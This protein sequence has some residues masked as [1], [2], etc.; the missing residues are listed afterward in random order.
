MRSPL[1]GKKIIVIGAGVGGL[2]AGILLA[3]LGFEVTIVEKN[4]QP[5]GLMN[6]YRRGGMDC[7]VGVHYVGALGSDE[8]LGRMFRVLDIDAE[9]LFSRM[10]RQGVVD[11]YLFDDF[12]FDFPTGIDEYERRLRDAFPAD[13][14][15]LNVLLANLRDI[16]SRMMDTLFL[17]NQGDPFSSIAYVRPMG[18]LLDELGAS[19]GLR[20]VLAVP[21]QLIGVELHECPIL[22]H[23][24]VTAG[25]LLSSWRLK[26][27]GARMTE[28]FADRYRRLKGHLWLNQAVVKINVENKRVTGVDLSTGERLKADGVVAAVHPKVL[29]G[30]LDHKTLRPSLEER[31]RGFKETDGVVAVHVALDAAAHPDID[32]NLYRLHADRNGQVKDGVFYQIRRGGR[33][34]ETLLSMITRSHY[35]DWLSWEHTQTGRRGEDYVEKKLALARDLQAQAERVLRPL[36]KA[37]LLDVF[38]PL[39]LRDYVNCPEGSCYGLLRSSGQLMKLT[40]LNNLSVGGLCLAGQNAVSPGVM[41]SMLGS[42]NAVRMIVGR[43]RFGRLFSL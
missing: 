41:G 30:L 27:S 29:L 37:R 35:Q 20:A 22:F 21:C 9:A 2:S 19:A 3:K 14:A 26:D 7:P 28:V 38:T 23:H 25:Y 5:G 13:A 15:C 12:V 31:I 6:S 40:T 39:T 33:P 11:R 16:A 8:P 42:F 4:P 34:D 1:D 24:M 43:E 36:Q 32:Y 17:L 18:D 10:G